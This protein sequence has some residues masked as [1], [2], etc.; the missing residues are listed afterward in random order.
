M[1]PLKSGGHK[2]NKTCL[3]MVY[4]GKKQFRF[5]EISFSA[6]KNREQDCLCD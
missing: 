3:E 2:N 5:N 4:L 1:G 6:S